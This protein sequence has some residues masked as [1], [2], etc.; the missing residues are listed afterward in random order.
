MTATSKAGFLNPILVNGNVV[1]AEAQSKLFSD[2]LQ[3]E[4][5]WHTLSDLGQR[6]CELMVFM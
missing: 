4:M 3:D 2:D 1:Q 5:F 6:L